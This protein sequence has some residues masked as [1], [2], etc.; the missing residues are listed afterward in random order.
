[1][2]K[3][4]SETYFGL[5][6][7]MTRGMLITVLWRSVGEPIAEKSAFTDVAE[8]AYYAPAVDWAAENG[9]VTG[10]TETIFNPD[11]KITREQLVTVLYRYANF[12]GMDTSARAELSVFPDAHIAYDYALDALQWAVALGL[13]NGVN[14]VGTAYLRPQGDATRSQVATILMRFLE[15]SATVA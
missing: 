12:R 10:V 7:A 1:L 14:E 2:F 9:I 6:I 5:D 3:G 13:I 11:G 8:D 4:M 15:G